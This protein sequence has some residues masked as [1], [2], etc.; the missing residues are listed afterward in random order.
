MNNSSINNSEKIQLIQKLR[1]QTFAGLNDCKVALEETNYD[2]KMACNNLHQKGLI[3]KAKSSNL[4]GK[5][6]RIAVFVDKNRAVFLS[7]ICQTDFVANT[8]QFQKIFIEIGQLIAESNVTN[9]KMVNTITAVNGETIEQK[10]NLLSSII[11]EFVVIKKVV[12]LTAQ[13]DQFFGYYTHTNAKAAA[14]ITFSSPKPNFEIAHQIAMHVVAMK[15]IYM[16]EKEI[17]EAYMKNE[18][19]NIIEKMRDRLKGKSQELCLR[20]IENKLKSQTNE[21]TLSK[22]QFIQNEKQTI[23]QLL[24]TNNMKLVNM[25]WESLIN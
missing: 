14:L 1:S 2:L 7:L 23:N 22:Q 9:E 16:N 12:I 21:I 10:L 5:T 18:K 24:I 20:I 19:V 6:G 11:G 13:Q 4:D 15:P 25:N 3:K 17:P 8:T